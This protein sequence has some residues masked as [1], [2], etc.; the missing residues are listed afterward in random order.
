MANIERD[1]AESHLRLDESVTLGYWWHPLL[2]LTWNL[3]KNLVAFRLAL[4]H[5]RQSGYGFIGCFQELPPEVG[6]TASARDVTKALVGDGIR[7]LGVTPAAPPFKHGRVG[8]FCSPGIAASSDAEHDARQRMAICSVTGARVDP[9]LVLGYHGE[10]RRDAGSEVSR[11]RIGA[12]A[13]REIDKRWGRGALIMLGDFNANPFDPEVCGSEGMYAVRDRADARKERASPLVALGEKQRPL[14]NPM[15]SLLPESA[16]RPAGTHIHDARV[17]LR[18]RLYD[19]ILLSPD[20]INA[21]RDPPEILTEVAGQS[22][23][24]TQG[25]LDESISDH[26]PVQVRV[27]I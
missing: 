4:A 25:S 5:L 24:S 22:L 16:T 18:W 15:W 10:S 2:L 17:T 20:L 27:T 21:I 23:L 6:T 13:R 9:L 3:A 12:D 26:L 8:L 1:L 7:C 11:G 19:Q 14:Y